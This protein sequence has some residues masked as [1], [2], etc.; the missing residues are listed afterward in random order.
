[1]PRETLSI[2]FFPENPDQPDNVLRR[3]LLLAPIIY[4]AATRVNTSGVFKACHKGF[5][6]YSGD[7][8][9]RIMSPV[10]LEAPVIINA[11]GRPG[12]LHGR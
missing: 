7:A 12:V 3:S 1:M 4:A 5:G 9:K 2:G 11:A 6:G 10:T 8:L